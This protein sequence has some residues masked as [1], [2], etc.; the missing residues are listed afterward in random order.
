MNDE[1]YV[2]YIPKAPPRLGRQIT[3]LVGAL[4]AAACSTAALLTIKQSMFAT[5]KFEYGLFREYTGA[6]G[7][8]P[9]PMLRTNAGTFLLVAPGKHGLST[10]PGFFTLQG[11]LIARGENQ[12]L[13]VLP[14]TIRVTDGRLGEAESVGLG[15][16]TLRGEIVDSKCY[17]GVMNPGEGK[18]HRD[19]AARC[20]A[21][22]VPPAFIARDLYGETRFMLLT[23]LRG[24]ISS[25]VGE[26]VELRGELARRASQLIFSVDP[27][28]MRHV[29]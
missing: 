16:F 12:M 7:V 20:I 5:S 23:G 26:P 2:G 15:S 27:T 14:E 25:W 8:E 18:V 9:Y 24:D 3:V 22:G 4:V 28:S 21:G 29:E 6:I 10:R 13:E 11:S 19:C 1:F 17:L